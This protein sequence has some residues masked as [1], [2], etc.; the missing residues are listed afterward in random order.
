MRNL[1]SLRNLHKV[2][3]ILKENTLLQAW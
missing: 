1:A 3:G 2:A